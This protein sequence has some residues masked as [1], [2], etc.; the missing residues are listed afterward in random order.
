MPKAHVQGQ[1]APCTA[2]VC[3]SRAEGKD[4]GR[5]WAIRPTLWAK[6]FLPFHAGSQNLNRQPWE[7]QQGPDGPG[8]RV[9]RIFL[10]LL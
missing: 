7:R 8:R 9:T 4:P 10:G 1:G 6:H 2:W 3:D 5:E